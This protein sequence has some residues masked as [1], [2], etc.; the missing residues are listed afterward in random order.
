MSRLLIGRQTSGSLPFSN[1][2]SE[3]LIT[4]LF[5]SMLVSLVFTGSQME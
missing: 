5:I 2:Q 4:N 3:C 1:C